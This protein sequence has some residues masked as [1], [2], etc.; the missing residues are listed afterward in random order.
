MAVLVQSTTAET[1][2]D[3]IGVGVLESLVRY[4]VAPPPGGGQASSARRRVATWPA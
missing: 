3:V 1:V 4:Q 2:A